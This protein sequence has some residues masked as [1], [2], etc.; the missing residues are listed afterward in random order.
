MDTRRTGTPYAS[1]MTTGSQ[2]PEDPA[3]RLQF[4]DP[5]SLRSADDSDTGWGESGAGGGTSRTVGG[6][7]DSGDSAADLARFLEEKPPHHL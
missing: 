6:S 2:R 1:C 7:G 3:A 4:D 5:L